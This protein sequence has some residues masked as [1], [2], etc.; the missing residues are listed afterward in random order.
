[1]HVENLEA[2]AEI[3]GLQVYDACWRDREAMAKG[4]VTSGRFRLE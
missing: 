2:P 4:R 1:M 3:L